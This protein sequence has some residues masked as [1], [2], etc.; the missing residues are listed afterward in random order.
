MSTVLKRV[1]R[2]V[3]NQFPGRMPTRYPG[4]LATAPTPFASIDAMWLSFQTMATNRTPAINGEN[5]F[6]LP[7]SVGLS[8]QQHAG[9][10]SQGR[11]LPLRRL[12]RD[13]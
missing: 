3:I 9:N 12:I 11:D 5:I 10:R 13:T 1:H 4:E 7:I 6:S 2:R 8:L